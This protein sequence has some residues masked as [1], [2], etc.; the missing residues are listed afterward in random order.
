VGFS[1]ISSFWIQGDRDYTT[2][3]V[4][5]RTGEDREAV[6]LY[7]KGGE[8]YQF[9]PRIDYGR[10]GLTNSQMTAVEYTIKQD[11]D[12][13]YCYQTL[14]I[15]RWDENAEEKNGMVCMGAESAVQKSL[16]RVPYDNVEYQ[17]DDGGVYRRY[18]H[19][20]LAFYNGLV[21]DDENWLWKK[22]GYLNCFEY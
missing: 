5:I 4:F 18:S 15:C 8:L 2:Y 20:M 10:L 6:L 17:W 9:E 7:E 12:V 13:V 21:G 3:P 14:S 16:F 1:G 22:R 11:A 19:T